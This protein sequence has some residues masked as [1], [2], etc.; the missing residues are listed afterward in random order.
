MFS[1]LMEESNFREIELARDLL[2]LRLGELVAKGSGDAYDGQGVA[3]V[4]SGRE[5]VEYCEGN[6]H[7][8]ILKISLG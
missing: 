3:D 4:G 7:G 6:V 1:R 5:D 8:G 2:L